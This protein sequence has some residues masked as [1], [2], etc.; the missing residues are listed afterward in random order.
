LSHGPVADVVVVAAGNSSRMAGTDKVMA[1]VAGR[2]L[3][4]WTLAAFD[5]SPEVERIVVTVAPDRVDTLAGAAW[6]PAKLRAVV[7]GRDRRQTS[8]AAGVAGLGAIDDDRILLVHDGAR[9]L[10]TA[11]TIAAV[12]Q[13]THDHGAAIPVLA[14]AETLKRTQGGVVLGTVDR[15]GLAAAQ[16]P[17]GVRAGILRAAYAM[18]PPD[19]PETWTDEASLLEACTIPVHAVDGEPDNLKVTLPTDLERVRHALEGRALVRCGIG[20]DSHPFGPH[21]GLAL[22]GIVVATAPR[23]H[24]HSDGDAA[25]HAICDALLGASGLG[26]LGRLFPAGPETPAGI[27]SGALLAEVRRRLE[28]DGWRV[29]SVDLTIVAGRPRL[30]DHLDAMRAAIAATLGLPTEAVNVKASTGNLDG[31]EG[32]GRS[33]SALAIATV[34]RPR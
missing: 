30:A 11:R 34:E 32:A 7:A 17:Q 6:L 25:L 15:Q 9:P 20:H 16:T 14:V 26:D 3:L 29:T 28:I 1:E 12:I 21:A 22:G 5:A 31:S 24:G 10:V 33:I 13:A 4:A 2:P 8:V 18:F 23:L 19:G 27:A